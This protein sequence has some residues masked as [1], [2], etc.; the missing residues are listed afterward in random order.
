MRPGRLQGEEGPAGQAPPGGAAGGE[1]RAKRTARGRSLDEG[2]REPPGRPRARTSLGTPRAPRRA[3][4]G[5]G[6]KGGRGRG[7][8]GSQEWAEAGDRVAP[9]WRADGPVP[10]GG[11]SLGLTFPVP[12]WRAEGPL[13][14]WTAGRL[15][16]PTEPR[17]PVSTLL[18]E[19]ARGPPGSAARKPRPAARIGWRGPT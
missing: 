1:A 12:T 15:D 18:P 19:V 14:T 16:Y 17:K 11:A 5:E 7:P 6:R 2:K 13:P 8:G 9:P 4:A 3:R 10:R